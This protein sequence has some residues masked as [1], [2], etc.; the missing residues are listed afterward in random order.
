MLDHVKDSVVRRARR[1][2]RHSISAIRSS[3][4]D[5]PSSSQHTEHS[6]RQSD[7]PVFPQHPG[8]NPRANKPLPHRPNIE[9]QQ[10]TPDRGFT[11]HPGINPL[12]SDASPRSPVLDSPRQSTTG[13]RTR[14]SNDGQDEV[15]HFN[16]ILSEHPALNPLGSGMAPRSEAPRHYRN[17][18]AAISQH[19]GDGMTNSYERNPR[20]SSDVPRHAINQQ[21]VPQRS[22]SRRQSGTSQDNTPPLDESMRKPLP[23]EPIQSG[24]TPMEHSTGRP[25]YPEPVSRKPVP[26][27]STPES[28]RSGQNFEK[29]HETNSARDGSM[30]G[31]GTDG[32]HT[33]PPPIEVSAEILQHVD[34]ALPHSTSNVEGSSLSSQNSKPLGNEQHYKLVNEDNFH[35][36]SKNVVA[37]ET[38]QGGTEYRAPEVTDF[39]AAKPHKE[40]YFDHEV[41]HRN[42][43]INEEI[44]PHFHTI[45]EPK[46]TRSIHYHEHRQVIQPI[47]DPNPIVRPAAHWAEDHKT[48]EIFKIPDALGEQVLENAYAEFKRIDG[49]NAYGDEAAV[50]GK[51]QDMRLG[52]RGN[53][54]GAVGESD[55]IAQN[56]V[57]PEGTTGHRIH[58]AG[59][60]DGA[61][62]QHQAGA[63]QSEQSGNRSNI[64]SAL[65]KSSTN[66][67]GQHTQQREFG[68]RGNIS[69]DLNK[70]NLNDQPQSRPVETTT[71]QPQSFQQHTDQE[72]VPGKTT[73]QRSYNSQGRRPSLPA[74]PRQTSPPPV[75]E[76][77]I[78]RP[79]LFPNV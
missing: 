15:L 21:Y 79:S 59:G 22:A 17:S 8:V 69:R 16:E 25:V 64:P 9:T 62:T 3:S 77:R 45:Y 41:H 32:K 43:A 61:N 10:D 31:V 42:A 52:D 65:D 71:A 66:N 20:S 53:P 37:E 57:S 4:R 11:Q 29:P 54:S 60:L 74:D 76:F 36:T 35:A 58:N 6:P 30:P 44:K 68:D 7:T 28:T 50:A 26:L 56:Y 63:F 46:R 38:P 47:S 18:S 67:Y 34:T 70:L 24:E 73:S 48:G 39:D 40:I 13:H 75:R 14:P 78:Q 27:G 2:S 55:I 33:R 23:L 19:E 49:C 1:L 5:S 72:R 51:F 12:H